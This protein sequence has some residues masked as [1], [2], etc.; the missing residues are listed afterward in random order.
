MRH[1]NICFSKF[2]FLALIMMAVI[3]TGCGSKKKSGAAGGAAGGMDGMTSG[4]GT[5]ASAT[6]GIGLG[7]L[8]RVHFPFDSANL[9]QKARDSLQVNA[10]TLIGN[11]RMRVLVEG[12]TDERGS[13]EYNI[14]LGE[15]RARATVEYLVNLGVPRARFD[16]KS[17]GEERPLDPGKSPEAYALNRRAEFIILSK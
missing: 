12:H 14:A 16:I 4:Y 8:E 9:D 6:G 2:G 10:R 1:F 7:T 3:S 15:R 11:G 17:W 13:N 5:G